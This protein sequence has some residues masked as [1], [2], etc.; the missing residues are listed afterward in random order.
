MIALLMV[1]GFILGILIFVITVYN[2]FIKRKNLVKEAWSGIDVQLR[3]RHDL[4]PNL[5]NTVKGYMKH[6]RELLEKIAEMRARSIGAGDIKDKAHLENGLSAMLKTLF[7][8]AEAYPELKANQNFLDLQSNLQQLEDQIQL[9]RRY[10]NGTVRDY[11]ILVESFPSSIIASF[12]GFKT[13]EYYEVE[14]TAVR[15]VPKIEF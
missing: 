4:I 11:N 7:A 8:V 2:M 9:A 10:Y 1:V 3:R 6:E 14:D 12:F 15:E 13:F 5:L